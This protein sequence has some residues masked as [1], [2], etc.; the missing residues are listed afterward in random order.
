MSPDRALL[1]L[2]A[3]VGLIGANSLVLAPI[4]AAVG[5][6]LD[7]AATDVMQAAAGFGMATA[8]SALLL[9]PLIDRL[10]AARMLRAMLVLLAFGTALSGAAPAFGWL[11]TG[12]VLAGIASGV[13]LP[14]SYALAAETAR[15]GQAA[16]ALGRVLTGWTLALIFGVTVSALLADF[17]NWR[18]IFAAT[19]GASVLLAVGT[20]GL[21]DTA[22]RPISPPWTALPHP[23]VPSGL[24]VQFALMGAFYVTYSFLGAHLSQIGLGPGHGAIPVLAYGIG[25]GLSGR[26]DPWLD[27][28]GYG[29]AAPRVF[30]AVA[31]ALGLIATFGATVAGLSL[32]FFLWGLANH[33]GLGLTVGRLTNAA[34]EERRGAVLGLNS[35][36]TYLAVVAGAAGGRPVFET[37]GLA[38]CATLGAALAALCAIEALSRRARSTAAQP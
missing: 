19:A 37:G 21:P 35:A 5:D 25:F 33:L 28:Q 13:A 24:L 38:L 14:A 7:R 36:V 4:S 16:Q 32:A 29:G 26:F 30:G 20:G 3:A 23:G 8:L 1:L 12:Q 6:S 2:M 11:L 15:P 34:G 10:G 31:L 27:R 9:A 22:G 17:V 18:T